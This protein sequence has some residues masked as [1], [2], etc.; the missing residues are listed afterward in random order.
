MVI[1]H[2]KLPDEFKD[3][4][5]VVYNNEIHIL[6]G[7]YYDGD[8][9][10]YDKH[11]KF[12]VSTSEWI[13]VSI[14][15][16]GISST[17]VV[18]YNNELYILGGGRTTDTQNTFYRFDNATS[19]WIR[20]DDLPFNSSYNK[21]IVYNN[22]IHVFD[23]FHYKYN[24]SEWVRL[25]DIPEDFYSI[26]SAYLHDGSLEIVT[27]YSDR[28]VYDNENDQWIFIDQLPYSTYDQITTCNDKIFIMLGGDRY[29]DE[30]IQSHYK[31][32]GE[33]WTEVSILPYPFYQGSAVVYNNEIHILGGENYDN[34]TSHYK[35]DNETSTWIQVSEIP[36]DFTG[37]FAIEHNNELHILG[38]CR[39]SSDIHCIW[40]GETWSEPNELYFECYYEEY[41]TSSQVFILDNCINVI[42]GDY[43]E[44]YYLD[45]NNE[46]NFREYAWCTEFLLSAIVKDN[47]L[48]L[49]CIIIDEDYNF[50]LVQTRRDLNGNENSWEMVSY[51]E[52][53][54]YYQ[55]NLGLVN[56]NDDVYIMHD[57]NLYKYKPHYKVSSYATKDSKLYI[58]N[59]FAISDNLQKTD[60]GFIV[61]ENGVVEIG[62]LE[63]GSNDINYIINYLYEALESKYGEDDIVSIYNGGTGCNGYSDSYYSYVRY[64]GTSLNSS[65]TTP[66]T[67]GTI[68]WTYE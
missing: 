65:E 66:S 47:Y 18:V 38:G 13:E 46:W 37:G 30:F 7:K 43:G 68:A 8:Y 56:Y 1:H 40:N 2:C 44:W 39:G 42:T 5:A 12:D 58:K 35:F 45:D 52:K 34:R 55:D 48:N 24:G 20:L 49:F 51:I 59:A 16:Y 27:Y 21:I 22:E 53:Y 60:Y 33:K 64:R 31:F 32:D 36:Y 28:Y 3:G 26:Y 57:Y 14:L 10:N 61:I 17:D 54:D 29:F 19:Q 50:S 6:G 11:Y 41:N 25:N 63:D 62:I 15:P 9:Y 4:S 67:N 23:D